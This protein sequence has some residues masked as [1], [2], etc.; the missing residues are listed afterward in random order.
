MSH[1]CA[2]PI[3]ANVGYHEL[4]HSKALFFF[5]FFVIVFVRVFSSV[6]G[7]L[8]WAFIAAMRFVR[9]AC[10]GFL[11]LHLQ[12]SA[13]C[14]YRQDL[15]HLFFLFVCRFSIFFFIFVSR[16]NLILIHRFTTKCLITQHKLS[17]CEI[18][19]KCLDLFM[20]SARN[21]FMKMG[22]LN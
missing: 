20:N 15:F 12:F 10:Y 9:F 22:F 19:C 7:G 21:W 13:R 6:L 14:L 17:L 8:S 11:D 5:H 4:F 16:C 3:A 2:K 1:F 18:N